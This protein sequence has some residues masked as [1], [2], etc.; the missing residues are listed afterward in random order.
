MLKYSQP[1]YISRLALQGR[2][3]LSAINSVS[4]CLEYKFQFIWEVTFFFLRISHGH[5][6]RKKDSNHVSEV[7]IQ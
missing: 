3:D 6:N 1:F 7:T 2:R 5:R 4:E